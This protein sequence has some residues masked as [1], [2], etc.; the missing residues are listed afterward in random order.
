[1]A[2][3]GAAS[4]DGEGENSLPTPSADSDAHFSSSA[5]W[6]GDRPARH[7]GRARFGAWRARTAPLLSGGG[8][9]R[10]YEARDATPAASL[11]AKRHGGRPRQTAVRRTCGGTNC[12]ARTCEHAVRACDASAGRGMMWHGASMM[13]ACDASAGTWH[14]VGGMWHDDRGMWHDA[15]KLFIV[16][17]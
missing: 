12:E 7:C 3:R 11:T 15:S 13:R 4:R 14:D 17:S 8:T 1:M 9:G 10:R 2:V 6:R 16:L 5:R